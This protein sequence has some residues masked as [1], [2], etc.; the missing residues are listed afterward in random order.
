[1]YCAH[2]G[3]FVSTP[4]SIKKSDERKGEVCIVSHLQVYIV[5]RL[6]IHR[7]VLSGAWPYRTSQTLE[8]HLA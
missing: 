5:Y 7:L 6:D 3:G 1:M 4:E 8:A 2:G